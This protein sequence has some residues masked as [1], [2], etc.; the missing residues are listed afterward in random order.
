MGPAAAYKCEALPASGSVGA[1]S[2]TPEAKT[3]TSCRPSLSLVII[4][5]ISAM[6]Y[7]YTYDTVPWHH[8][9]NATTVFGLYN[10]QKECAF[11]GEGFWKPETEHMDLDYDLENNTFI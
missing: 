11:C 8:R 7:N 1:F 10:K 2:P 4:L 3:L 9:T 5:L 6:A